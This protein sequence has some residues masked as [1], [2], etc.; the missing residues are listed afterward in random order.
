MLSLYLNTSEKR[1]EGTIKFQKNYTD[2]RESPQ[3]AYP[4]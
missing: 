3:K 4:A 1:H 2:E